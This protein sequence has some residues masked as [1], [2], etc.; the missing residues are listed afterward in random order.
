[1]RQW[2]SQ[3]FPNGKTHGLLSNLQVG[4]QAGMLIG[5]GCIVYSNH[6]A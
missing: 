6:A 5:F 3:V 1:M 4:Q 2:T